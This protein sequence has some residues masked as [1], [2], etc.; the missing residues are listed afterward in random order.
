MIIVK[1]QK[2]INRTSAGIVS[3][4]SKS[5]D[6]HRCVQISIEFPTIIM[7]PFPNSPIPTY[8]SDRSMSVVFLFLFLLLDADR[9]R[10]LTIRFGSTTM[11]ARPLK[12]RLITSD[13][14]ISIDGVAMAAGPD[15]LI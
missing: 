1:I 7:L 8:N 9:L 5:L 14:I 10:W 4:W 11:A 12:R 2:A 15:V 13:C 6:L 3:R